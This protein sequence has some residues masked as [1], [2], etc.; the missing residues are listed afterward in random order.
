MELPLGM[1]VY[2]AHRQSDESALIMGMWYYK[3]MY[4]P[5]TIIEKKHSVDDLKSRRCLF[6]V[7]TGTFSQICDLLMQTDKF[8]KGGDYE[9]KLFSGLTDQ[10]IAPSLKP[11][12]FDDVYNIHGKA[13]ALDTICP[14]EESQEDILEQINS[15][16]KMIYVTISK[17][18]SWLSDINKALS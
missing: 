15:P 3:E 12:V 10:L 13:L 5:T 1:L 17:E 6:I 16:K 4:V 8:K 14:V 2:S 11:I 18:W 9:L 7:V